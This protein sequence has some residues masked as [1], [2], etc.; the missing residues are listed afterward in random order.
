MI[1]DTK[2]YDTVRCIPI[3]CF[4][5]TF[6]FPFPMH[7]IMN[8]I[9]IVMYFSESLFVARKHKNDILILTYA[10][11]RSL[12]RLIRLTQRDFEP[13]DLFENSVGHIWGYN[14]HNCQSPVYHKGE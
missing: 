1:N 11:L 7:M 2:R 6:T 3:F 9:H 13:C 8:P 5:F 12:L 4:L 10:S 14:E